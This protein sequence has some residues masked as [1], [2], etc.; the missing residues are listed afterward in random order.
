MDAVFVYLTKPDSSTPD[1]LSGIRLMAR[2]LE[3]DGYDKRRCRPVFMTAREGC[4]KPAASEITANRE[5]FLADVGAD[6]VIIVAMGSGVMTPL[7]KGYYPISLVRGE[8]VPVT[9]DMP[10]PKGS[11]IYGM[12]DPAAVWSDPGC[13]NLFRRDVRHLAAL[14]K[15]TP[16]KDPE[17]DN[18]VVHTAEEVETLTRSLPELWESVDPED[19]FLVVDCEWHGRNWMEPG[20]YIRTVQIG[21]APGAAVTVELYRE[22]PDFNSESAWPRRLAERRKMIA[23][24][25]AHPVCMCPDMDAMWKAL[26]GLLQDSRLPIIGHNVIAD[27]QWLLS[28]GVDIRGNVAYDTMLAEHLINSDGPFRLDEVAMRRTPF[29]RY[30]KDVDLWVHHHKEFC[31]GGYGAV[32][33]DLLLPYGGADVE[34]PRMIMKAQLPILESYGMLKPRGPEKEYPSL[35][36]STL[37]NELATD[38]LERNGLPV[39]RERLTGLIDAY[40]A[41]RAQLLSEITLMAMALGMPDFNPNSQPQMRMLLFGKLGLTPVKTTGGQSWGDAVG[42]FEPDAEDMPSSST[43]KSVLEML[44]NSHPI[45]KKL[46]HFRRIDQTCKTWLRHPD[47]D[48]EGGLEPLIWADGKLHASFLPLT[49]TGRYKTSSPNCFP[50]EVEVLTSKGWLRWDEAY[51]KRET[52]IKLAQWNVESRFREITFERPE[53]WHT[54]RNR[55]VRVRT[56]QQIDIIATPEHKFEVFSRKDPSKHKTVTTEDLAKCTEYLIP[57]AG[58]LAEG[59]GSVHLSNSDATL[60]CAMQADGYIVPNGGVEFAFTKARKIERLRAALDAGGWSYRMSTDRSSSGKK[61]IRFYV[62]KKQS[63]KRSLSQYKR[64]GDWLLE[65]DRDSLWRLSQEVFE[66]DG[67]RTGETSRNYASSTKENTDWVQ[68]LQLLFN[69]R[70]HFREYAAL[71]G[72]TS[73]QVDVAERPLSHLANATCE[74]LPEAV[75]YCVT[76]PQHSVIVRYNGRVLFTRQSQNF[77]KKAEG[78]LSEIFGEGKVPPTLRT[79]V[80]PPEGWMMMEGDFCQAELFT[81]ANISNDQ[82]MIRLLTTPGLDL[83]DSTTLSSFNM[84]MID[85]HDREVTEDDLVK[86]AAEIGAGSDEFQHYMKTMRYLQ[87]DGRMITR[88]AFKSGPRISAKSLCA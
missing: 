36:D 74:H 19:R 3:E 40:Q 49:S 32:P 21:Y 82:N 68:I 24:R 64:F 69:R 33:A 57:Q 14:M 81:M 17:V 11:L 30:C 79:I 70:A 86:L 53:A 75:V 28:F 29:G 41:K 23:D 37:L 72:N 63:N 4:A 7:T 22:H 85:E 51:A 2:M 59:H 38:E 87:V 43:D 6:P 25:L 66:W 45:V 71:S 20:R 10:Y 78:Y 9:D 83:H 12:F 50:A 31:Q 47:E 44:Q 26:K 52:G 58:D 35:L 77:P 88:A 15:G 67:C 61:R 13:E 48:G 65:C 73:Y 46:L 55:L 54:G 76:M 62:Y 84:K 80:K 39:D 8:A 56:H 42:G 27:W 60:I 34:C 5:K 18:V 1:R 16:E